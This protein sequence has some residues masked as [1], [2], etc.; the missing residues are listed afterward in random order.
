MRKRVSG[1]T[2]TR[3]SRSENP[4]PSAQT[5]SPSMPIATDTPGIPAA[6]MSESTAARASS[7]ASR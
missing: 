4:N 7:I 6:S 1:V 5:I 2:A 3:L